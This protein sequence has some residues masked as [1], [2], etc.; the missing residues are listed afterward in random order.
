MT[1]F[2]RGFL[3]RWGCGV[4]VAVALWGLTPGR[5]AAEVRRV[6]IIPFSIHADKDLSFL[7]KGITAMLSSRLT[8]IG[9]VIVM[10]QAAVADSITNLPDP[11]TREAAAE[12]GRKAGADFVAFGSLTVFGD[13]ISTDARFVEAPTNTILV[14]FSGTGQSQ[15]DVIGHINDFSAEVNARVFGRQP[16]TTIVVPPADPAPVDPDQANPEK[17]IWGGDG[18]MRIQATNPDTDYTGAKLWRSRR[19]NYEVKGLAIGDVD[20][21]GAVET[22]FSGDNGVAIFRFKEGQ[23]LKITD[24]E[25]GPDFVGIG[26]DVADINANGK[27]EIFLIGRTEKYWPKTIVLEWDGTQFQQIQVITDWFFRVHHDPQTGRLALFGQKGSMRQVGQRDTINPV[28]KGPLY[29]M[30]WINGA[31]ESQQTYPLPDQGSVF[32]F[33]Y[34]DLTGDG[35]EDW[36]TYTDSDL[37]RLSTSGGREEWT[38]SEPYGGSYTF[39]MSSGV[40]RQRES[41]NKLDPDP[42]PMSVFYVPQRVLLTDFDK[43]GQNEVLVVQNYDFTQGLMQ[44]SRSFRD[45]RFECLAWDNV[46]L[47]ALWRTRKFSGYISD[48]NL[49]DFDNDGKDELVFAVVKK[50]GD[51]ITGESKSYLVSWDPYQQGDVAPAD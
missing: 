2:F 38:S 44:R 10:D 21:D 18:G 16:Q 42:L 5:S 37:L 29:R 51:P 15:G 48:Y 33:A 11:V 30:A 28:V 22:V 41:V 26:L 12:V 50:V 13:N 31:Y 35:V 43:D 39:L 45:G 20:G 47:R 3:F 27:A 32:G 23:F 49:G 7:R 17:R 24:V 8:D 34:G 25:A 36:V 1:M 6:L 4:L 9:K 40:F 19:F 14:T 46:G